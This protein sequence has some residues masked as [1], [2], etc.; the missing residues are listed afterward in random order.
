MGKPVLILIYLRDWSW[1]VTSQKH[2]AVAFW[3]RQWRSKHSSL[4]NTFHIH[5]A[6]AQGINEEKAPKIRCYK[7][8]KPNIFDPVHAS[9]T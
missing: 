3:E 2:L 8:K 7:N 6:L 4:A 1:H 9:T 5:K